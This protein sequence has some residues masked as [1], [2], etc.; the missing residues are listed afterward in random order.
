MS[1]SVIK[2]NDRNKNDLKNHPGV[3]FSHNDSIK[4]KVIPVSS[5]NTFRSATQT[6]EPTFRPEQILVRSV[7]VPRHLEK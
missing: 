7:L 5:K 4:N 3:I 2:R 6:S 1:R